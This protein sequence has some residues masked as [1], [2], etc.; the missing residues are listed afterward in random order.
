MN[1]NFNQGMPNQAP[2]NPNQQQYNQYNQNPPQYNNNQNNNASFLNGVSPQLMSS[3]GGEMLQRQTSS[4][5]SSFS[6]F[7]NSLK[8]YFAVNN[9]LIIYFSYVLINYII[10]NYITMHT[11]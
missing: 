3:I 10:S 11:Y 4:W 5:T 8:I 1:P 9:R 2:Y 6:V 7:W